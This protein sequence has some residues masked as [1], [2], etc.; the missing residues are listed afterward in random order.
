[1][2]WNYAQRIQREKQA[3]HSST[4][5]AA[6]NPARRRSKRVMSPTYERITSGLSLRESAREDVKQEATGSHSAR[7]VAPCCGFP[8]KVS[9]SFFRNLLCGLRCTLLCVQRR[10][11]ERGVVSPCASNT[12]DH[13]APRRIHLNK[14]TDAT[15][16]ASHRFQTCSVAVGLSLY[17]KRSTTSASESTHAISSTLCRLRTYRCSLHSAH[18]KSTT[19][20]RIKQ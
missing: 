2:H 5:V 6:S 12:C 11:N 18:P 19:W 7:C 10:L 17:A 3:S 16:V 4:K 9:F 14:S 8:A 1:M 15:R 13:H 20:C